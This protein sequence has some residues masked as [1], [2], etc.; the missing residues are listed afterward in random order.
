MFTPT[1]PSW[2]KK[3]KWRILFLAFCLSLL[4]IYPVYRNF[5]Y[6][7]GLLTYERHKAVIEGHSDFYNP[8]QYRILCP[9]AVEGIMW[10]YN[11]T[12]DKI[13]PIEKKFQVHIDSDSG[14][15][16]G[17]DEFVKLSNTP[18]VLKYMLIFT[19]FR[20]TEHIFIFYLAWRLWSYF[21]K[22]KWLIFFGINF[23]ALAF[24]N[25]VTAADLSFN[26]YL[27]IILYLVTANLIVY[28]K[29]KM[30]LFLIVPLA[31]FNRETGLLIPALYF[32]SE[33]NFSQFSLKNSDW[34]K[35]DFPKRNVWINTIV[36]YAIFMAIFIAIR[37]HY[38]YVPQQVWKTK[39]GWSM[40]KLNLFSAIGVKAYL[41]L[42]GSFGVIPFIILYKFKA[43]P[44]LL[45][46]WFL[47]LV[48]V[49]FAV[50]YISVVAYQTRLFMVPIILVFIPMMLWLI[51]REV[52]ERAAVTVTNKQTGI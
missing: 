38:G 23:L 5:Y 45:K 22:S 9:F 8:W 25:A 15:S 21:I 16:A 42:I 19:L 10:I 30:W 27:D 33:T 49:W 18:G 43:F 52:T 51:E 31:A 4:S 1:T 11:N 26:T 6:S 46:K 48:P 12:V 35:I 13:F 24:G 36:L 17:T 47:F 50:H 41:E 37:W 29:N 39:A 40:L 7:N 32:L 3:D 14:I 44:H 20:F 2:P 34:K 28:N